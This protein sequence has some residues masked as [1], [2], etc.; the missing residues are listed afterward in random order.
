MPLFVCYFFVKNLFGEVRIFLSAT[1]FFRVFF[2]VTHL[3][4][5]ASLVIKINSF[6]SSVKI[7]TNMIS[8]TFGEK[9]S[10]YFFRNKIRRCVGSRHRTGLF[11]LNTS[12]FFLRLYS[13][14][15]SD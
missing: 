8:V 1:L 4:P 5:R 13:A 11:F 2:L 15:I 6:A 7:N 10:V 9:N 12:D 14:V 3:S